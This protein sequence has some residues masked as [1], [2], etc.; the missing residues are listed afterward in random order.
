[1]VGKPPGRE[2]GRSP[3]GYAMIR[4][5]GWILKRKIR[6]SGGAA[7]AWC[8]WKDSNLRHMV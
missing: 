5:D 7:F 8:A 6:R 2:D 3:G 1:M 4:P